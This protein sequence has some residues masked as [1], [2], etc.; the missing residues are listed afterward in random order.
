MK[1]EPVVTPPAEIL[2]AQIERL[3]SRLKQIE[4]IAE[5]VESI[6][7]NGF[8]AATKY[9]ESKA[10]KDRK[11]AE[12]ADEQHQR[13]IELQDKLHK[14]SVVVLSLIVV[15]VFILVVIAMVMGQFDL[16]KIILGSSLAVAGG[17]G[18]AGLF[19]GR[20]K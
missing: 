5:T 15:V 19:R 9:L 6:A 1:A 2:P 10:E 4:K 17:A 7:E 12:A 20:G 8:A 18:I 14:R 3:D 11:E 16:V 13:E